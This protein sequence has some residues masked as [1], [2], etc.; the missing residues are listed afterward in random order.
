MKH[1]L[2]SALAII[3]LGAS[4]PMTTKAGN[5]DSTATKKTQ[6]T[7]RSHG[8]YA[9]I[10]VEPIGVN[11][12]DEFWAS[13]WSL[14]SVSAGYQICPYF[15]I[16]GGVGYA[17]GGFRVN[18]DSDWRGDAF[19]LDCY[20]P[21]VPVFFDLC[22]NLNNRRVVP[23]IPIRIGCDI[24]TDPSQGN[25]HGSYYDDDITITD[26]EVTAFA[27]IGFGMKVHMSKASTWNLAVTLTGETFKYT[28]NW[29]PECATPMNQD[30]RLFAISTGFTF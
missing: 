2:Y 27:S 9:T 7:P 15:A 6:F 3:L 16:G 11:V 29:S 28:V 5:P 10:N 18:Y 23:Y 24:V 12:V 25:I 13:P 26:P 17:W 4:V 8:W 22:V 14:L 20:V 19:D 1:L 21:V 30:Y